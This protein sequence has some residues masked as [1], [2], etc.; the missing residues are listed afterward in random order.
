MKT[1]QQVTYNLAIANIVLQIQCNNKPQFDNLFIHIDVF[2]IMM[3]FFKAVEKFINNCGIMNIIV[4]AKML[5]NLQNRL[6]VLLLTSISTNTS[7]YI[8]L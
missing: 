7:A 1:I 3:A 8:Q 5:A 2:H 4:N 6:I